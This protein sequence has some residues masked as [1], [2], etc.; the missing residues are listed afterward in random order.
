[1]RAGNW[2]IALGALALPCAAQAAAYMKFD[3]IKGESR[4]AAMG[5]K[6]EGEGFTGGVRVASGDVTGDGTADASGDGRTDAGDYTVW[7]DSAG[8]A[9]AAP[10]D[11]AAPGPRPQAASLLLPAVQKVREVAAARPAGMACEVGATLRNL[12]IRNE[13]TAQ[14]V[15]VPMATVTACS[16]EQVT[17]NFSKVEAMDPAERPRRARTRE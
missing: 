16:A 7:R 6:G 9:S 11:V 5:F 17:L 3:G 2:F 1:M 14:V 4:I 13:E 12:T 15:R 10:G 8:A